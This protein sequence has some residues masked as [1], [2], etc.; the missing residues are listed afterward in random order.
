MNDN[1]ALEKEAVSVRGAGESFD[2]SPDCASVWV[3]EKVSPDYFF[4]SPKVIL[5]K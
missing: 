3:V 5:I 1:F 2:V 4:Q